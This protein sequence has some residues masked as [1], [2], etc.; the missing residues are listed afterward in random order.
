[1]NDD[2]PAGPTTTP[3]HAEV[4]AVA[5]ELRAGLTPLLQALAGA[6]P[7]PVRLTQGIGLDKSLAS[8][9]VQAI[10]AGTDLDFLHQVP[11]PTG[12]RIL[13]ER[14]HGHA[15]ES[16]VRDVEAGVRRFDALLDGLPGGRQALDARIGED[17]GPIRERREQM[18]RQASFKAV[19]F[20]F[21]HFSETLTTALFVLPSAMPGRVDAIEVHR[22]IGL[23]RLS[24]GMALPLLSIYAGTAP[25]G[26][27]PAMAPLAAGARRDDPAAYLVAS[28][29]SRP[30]PAMDVV[31]EGAMTTFVLPPGDTVRLPTR[32]TTA[33]RVLR[34]E[35]AVPQAAFAILR[36]YM[37]HTPCHT[38]VRDLFLA[39]GLWPD[40]RPQVG[41][42]LPG[43]G[44]TP[45]V[46]VEPGTP[47]LRRVNL[48]ARI[49]QLPEGRAGLELPDVADHGEALE[50]AL[51][52]AGADAASWRG[53]RC[54]MSY[55]VPLI[56]MQLAVR[57][58]GR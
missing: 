2:T 31:H 27:G 18:A 30:L 4:A 39:P 15:D 12:L 20:L 47:H 6:T 48:T 1:L 36:N 21:G 9:L 28:A 11:S 38:L 22:R 35:S 29:S 13:L 16:L 37:L 10:R 57:F 43:P 40:A 56:E 58:A 49:E 17:S 46:E 54:R 51:A 24:S 55:P 50:A 25:A 14:A 42:Y 52:M 23:Q 26:D 32:L 44:G 41:F 33:W 7:R 45:P 34:A 3:P 8:R 19:S 5:R 53:W